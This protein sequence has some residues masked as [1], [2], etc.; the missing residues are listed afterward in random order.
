MYDMI[1]RINSV[2]EDRGMS[3]RNLADKTGIPVS[4]LARYLRRGNGI[5]LDNMFKIAHAL[6][7]DPWQLTLGATMSV[8][9]S[10]IEIIPE[11][12]TRLAPVYESVSAGL[13]I[14]ANSDIVEY[15]PIYAES[16]AEAEETLVIRVKGNSMSPKIEDG[17]LVQ[18][19]R[20]PCIESGSIGVVL[21]DT[22]HGEEGLVKRIIY[23]TGYIEL[24]S[25]NQEYDSVRFSGQ[26]ARKVKVVGVVR[27]I[28]KIC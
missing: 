9:H 5:P 26:D 6:G 24:Q 25:I 21:L 3:I 13:G 10:E 18:V 20:T 19:W 16:K 4:T 1:D 17:D 7:V 8:E 15:A 11:E 14:D 28:T 27:R 12:K 22:D 23:G 2:L